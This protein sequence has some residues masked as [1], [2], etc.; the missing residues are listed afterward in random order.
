MA[1]NF[2]LIVDLKHWNLSDILKKLKLKIAYEVRQFQ[3]V[4][5]LKVWQNRFWDHIIRNQDDFNKHIDYIH[6]NPVKHGLTTNPIDWKFSS[7]D[8]YKEAGY[9]QDDWGIIDAPNF[10]GEFGE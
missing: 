4:Q 2:H 9:Y 10:N 8:K 1:I 5:R 6:F 3:G 7:F